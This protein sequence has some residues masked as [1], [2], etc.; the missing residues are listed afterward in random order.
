MKHDNPQ[1]ASSPALGA[2]WGLHKLLLLLLLVVLVISFSLLPSLAL[3]Q[4]SL[5]LPC[6]EG[7][8]DNEQKNPEGT[9]SS[10]LERGKW[11]A[12]AAEKDKF[13]EDV[14]FVGISTWHFVAFILVLCLF[15]HFYGLACR[16]LLKGLFHL[17][18][19]EI[20]QPFSSLNIFL[21]Q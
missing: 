12:G 2:Q 4:E 13:R 10:P 9:K 14:G 21:S 6:G 18:L 19:I 17:D 1:T 15:H 7:E 16:H 3:D 11:K 5:L 20:M 8:E